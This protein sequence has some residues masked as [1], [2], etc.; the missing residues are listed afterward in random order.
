MA[1]SREVMTD[2]RR[3]SV[4]LEYLKAFDNG[5][6]TSNGG[7]ILD[8][9]A[10]DAQVYF[11][12]RG[13]AT[14][15][16][17]RGRTERPA[18]LRSGGAHRDHRSRGPVPAGRAAEPRRSRLD[19]PAAAPGRP[20]RMGGR[21]PQPPVRTDAGHSYLEPDT[22][23]S[24]WS[25]ISRNWSI[26]PAGGCGSPSIVSS[27]STCLVRPARYAN[28]AVARTC[29]PSTVTSQSPPGSPDTSGVSPTERTD[30]AVRRTSFGH[31][32]LVS[33]GPSYELPP[34]LSHCVDLCRPHSVRQLRRC[35]RTRCGAQVR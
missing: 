12:K 19:S 17:R 32:A 15:F 5:G 4:A 7:S 33:T 8:L 31:A 10:E 11:P 13:I 20:D 9:F 30:S 14:S 3:K 25:Q 29:S 22:F 28:T 21:S 24:C 1:L 26:D 2:E 34:G 18:V 27:P 16:R 35:C 6:V 23:P